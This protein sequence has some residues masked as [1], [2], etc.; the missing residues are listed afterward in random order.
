[1]ARNSS[2]W[3][4]AATSRSATPW[5][6][7]SSSSGCR[8]SRFR[9]NLEP[10]H[11]ERHGAPVLAPRGS[12]SASLCAAINAAYPLP[13]P[14]V[15]PPGLPS[16]AKA[17]RGG[18]L[19]ET[20]GFIAYK[21][22]PPNILRG[23]WGLGWLG[24][25]ATWVSGWIRTPSLA[26]TPAGTP[27]P[28]GAGSVE[29]VPDGPVRMSGCSAQHDQLALFKEVGSLSFQ[30]HRVGEKPDEHYWWEGHV[31]TRLYLARGKSRDSASQGTSGTAD[32]VNS[33]GG[34]LV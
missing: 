33:Q 10:A 34:I 22:L 8:S 27:Y 18:N 21:G 9:L 2:P 31:P 14:P 12:P 6:T 17:S 4:R 7:R 13:T 15:T 28:A 1:M 3:R 19:P 30:S 16:V 32:Q 11:R 23:F 20:T 25:G 5:A 26:A 24:G 29:Q